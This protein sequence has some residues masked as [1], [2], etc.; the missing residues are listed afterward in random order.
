VMALLRDRQVLGWG[1]EGRGD[2][3]TWI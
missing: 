3:Q 2:T 1:G